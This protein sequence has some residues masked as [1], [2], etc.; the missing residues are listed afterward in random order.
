MCSLLSTW[1]PKDS[2]EMAALSLLAHEDTRPPTVAPPRRKQGASEPGPGGH[3][4][5]FPETILLTVDTHSG[6]LRPTGISLP[7]RCPYRKFQ[8]PLVGDTFSQPWRNRRAFL[9]GPAGTFTLS[10]SVCLTP[11]RP[12]QHLA[13]FRGFPLLYPNSTLP[14]SLGGQDAFPEED[15]E[16]QRGD[17]TCLTQPISP[18]LV[19]IGSWSLFQQPRAFVRW[20]WGVVQTLATGAVCPATLPVSLLEMQVLRPCPRDPQVIAALSEI[21][22]TLEG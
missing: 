20:Q 22:G 16:V 10:M 4:L 8:M 2:W 6:W 9:T 1:A 13:F 12:C 5:A 3:A 7:S 14:F 15:P 21:W 17:L 11:S 19:C 18:G